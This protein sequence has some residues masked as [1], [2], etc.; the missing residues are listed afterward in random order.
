MFTCR[1]SLWMSTYQFMFWFSYGVYLPFRG[2][3]LEKLGISD[4][5]VGMLVGFGLAARCVINFTLTP[6]FHKVGHL[7]PFLRRSMFLSL[8]GFIAFIWLGTITPS[9]W[10]LALLLVI[11]NLA[12]GPAVAISDAISNHYARDNRL[13]YGYTRLW[14]AVALTVASACMG[15]VIQHFGVSAVPVMGAVGLGA[16]FIGTLMKPSVP[17]VCHHNEEEKKPNIFKVL[18]CKET[19]V[20]LLVASLLEGSHGG[21]YFFSTV[22]WAEK[23]LDS[24]TIGYL[25]SLSTISVIVFYLVS[26]K[27]F[28]SW[29]VSTLFKLAA[30]AV[31]LRWGLMAVSTDLP[32]LIFC[33]I[34]HGITFS[35]TILSSVRYVEENRKHNYVALQSLYHATPAGFVLA[36][37][38]AACGWLMHHSDISMFWFMAVMGI[39]C[40]FLT[41]KQPE[42]CES[43]AS[44]LQTKT[45]VSA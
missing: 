42:P 6:F 32:V 7:I 3:W 25:W 43:K 13:D 35:G 33:Q 23:G 14:G 2:L 4:A 20:F 9:F 27:A 16:T 22:Y 29:K 10:T 37:V 24:D 31:V 28:S 44:V 8:L 15:W 36:I 40:I 21:Y 41:V 12:I 45:L 39:P 26:R 19:L 11:F 38:S 17:M 34:L 30:V 5:D 18:C 1:P